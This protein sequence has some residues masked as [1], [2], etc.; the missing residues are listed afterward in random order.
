MRRKISLSH[1]RGLNFLKAIVGFALL[2]LFAFALNALFAGASQTVGQLQVPFSQVLSPTPT[3]PISQTDPI[4][5]WRI[6]TDT[7]AGYSIKYPPDADVQEG[8]HAG[9]KYKIVDFNFSYTP[10][11]GVSISVG[12]NPQN[13]SVEHFAEQV[14]TSLTLG[15]KIEIDRDLLYESMQIGSIRALKVGGMPSGYEF[16]AFVPYKDKIYQLS[17]SQDSSQKNR[18]IFDLMLSTFKP[19]Q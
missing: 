17:I 2:A 7:D 19:L 12:D 6:Y 9:E 15:K 1:K 8:Q 4:A 10:Y 16:T 11:E 18:E 14:Y 13:L 3:I 5:G